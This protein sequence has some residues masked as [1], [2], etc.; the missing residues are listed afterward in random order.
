MIDVT[1]K[2][3]EEIL[4][5]A[6]PKLLTLFQKY[7]SIIDEIEFR[8][9]VYLALD[10]IKSSE[11]KVENIEKELIKTVSNELKFYCDIAYDSTSAYLKEIGQYKLLTED[12]EFVLGMRMKNGDLQAKEEFINANL[13]LVVRI[14]KKYLGNGIEFLDLIQ[15]GNI[16]LIQA[17]EKFDVELGFRFSTYAPW[18]ILQAIT[19][20]ITDKGRT[21]RY[22]CHIGEKIFSYNTNYHEL[23]KELGRE[24]TISELANAMNV[25]KVVVK[26]I[27]SMQD[28]PISLN[29]FVGEDKTTE[30][31][32]VLM[33]DN[34]TAEDIAIRNTLKDEME[35][36]FEVC[37]LTEKEK[38]VLKMRFGW[39][40]TKEMSLEEIANIL[41]LSREGVRQKESKG[42]NKIRKSRYSQALAEYT[43]AP[44]KSMEILKEY[45]MGLQSAT[46]M[47]HMNGLNFR[48]SDGTRKKKGSRPRT[49]KELLERF[50]KEQIKTAIERL[51]DQYKEL[52][53]DIMLEDSD[54]DMTNEE[55]VKVFNTLQRLLNNPKKTTQ[56]QKKKL[57]KLFD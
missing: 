16:G 51:D 10:N 33:Y 53:Y 7:S 44:E 34:T 47:Y 13:R 50:T 41:H 19:R 26:K 18:W 8:T 32:R 2:S 25:S 54:L 30:L 43:D 57:K 36:A 9:I 23:L 4:D 6:F 55:N 3:D 21:I 52:L 56:S 27:R 46:D 22:P 39:N 37:K 11:R 31:E 45:I 28:T 48:K 12:E 17:V 15:E 29:E 1:V 40:G 42:I 38:T 35:K 49:F 14:A 20:A 24:P 5:K